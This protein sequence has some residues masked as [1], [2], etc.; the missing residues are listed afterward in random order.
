LKGCKDE[1]VDE[2]YQKAGEVNMKG[3]L[4]LL[5]EFGFDGCTLSSDGGVVIVSVPIWYC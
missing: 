1:A 3:F 2:I 4:L 5:D